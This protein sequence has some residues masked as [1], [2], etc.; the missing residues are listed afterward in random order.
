MGEREKL[1]KKFYSRD[2][3]IYKLPPKHII[4]KPDTK[5]KTCITNTEMRKTRFFISKLTL[6]YADATVLYIFKDHHLEF[7]TQKVLNKYVMIIT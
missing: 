5:N 7:P 3:L 2:I 4:L 1:E 6:K